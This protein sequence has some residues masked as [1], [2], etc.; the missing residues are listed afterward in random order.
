MGGESRA[1]RAKSKKGQL[2]RP[3][4]PNKTPQKNTLFIKRKKNPARANQEK[5]RK[6]FCWVASGSERR[7][8]GFL[9]SVQSRFVQSSE[10][11]IAHI[12]R[13][14]EEVWDTSVGE[15]TPRLVNPES[16][17]VDPGRIE[18]PPVQC[19]CTVIPLYY[20][21]IYRPTSLRTGRVRM[22]PICSR[23]KRLTTNR[24]PPKVLRRRTA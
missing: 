23:A 10:Y 4:L 9:S 14:H 13:G 17:L 20:G 24:N 18:L 11:P 12:W 1:G 15:S 2:P 19:E 6:L 8:A 5:R 16:K 7:R 21:P 3:A 22:F